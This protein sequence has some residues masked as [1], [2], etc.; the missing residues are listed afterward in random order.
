MKRTGAAL[1]PM[2]ATIGKEMPSGEG[3]VFE[4]KYDGIR[5]LAFVADGSVAL[6]SRNGNAKT[7]QFPEIAEA[8]LALSRK[9]RRSF[10]LD[11]EIVALDGDSPA[12]FQD[13]QSRMH[14]SDPRAIAS[15]RDRTPVV[16]LMTRLQESLAQGTKA[17]RRSASDG[18]TTRT[19]SRRRSSRRK[20]A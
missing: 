20:S 4:P 14:V 18:T 8:L 10:V 2:L 16:D 19:T 9:K 5:I 6:L 13:L 11:G 3:W 12:R 1:T 17:R 15:H 7:A